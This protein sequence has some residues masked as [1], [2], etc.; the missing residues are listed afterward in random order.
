MIRKNAIK[1]M[2]KGVLVS[3][4]SE[5]RNEHASLLLKNPPWLLIALRTKSTFYNL[6]MDTALSLAPNDQVTC[7]D[8]Y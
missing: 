6:G 3:D 7:R 8:V 5:H 1:L 4:L 2:V